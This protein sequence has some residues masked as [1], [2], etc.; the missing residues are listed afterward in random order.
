MTPIAIPSGLAGISAIRARHFAPPPRV[1]PP[2]PAPKPAEEAA[3]WIDAVGAAAITR[4]LRAGGYEMAAARVRVVRVVE[5]AAGW[6]VVNLQAGSRSPPIARHLADA[7]AMRITRLY[8]L[9]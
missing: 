1:A 5:E 8:A 7:M 4:H 6:V 3:E 2:P 9:A